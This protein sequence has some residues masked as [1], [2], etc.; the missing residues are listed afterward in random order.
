[1][2]DPRAAK[3]PAVRDR[4]LDPR[5]E[6]RRKEVKKS[7]DPHVSATAGSLSISSGGAA[8]YVG[9]LAGSAYLRDRGDGKQKD[10]ENG[11]SQRP[12]DYHYSRLP[13]W[14]EGRGMIDAY[15]D[16]VNWM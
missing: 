9:S 10:K 8:R 11:S 5:I 15:W 13:D 2:K 7:N 16:H 6:E 12:L 4:A 3:P 1:M 14:D